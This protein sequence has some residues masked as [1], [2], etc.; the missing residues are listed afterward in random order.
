MSGKPS[1]SRTHQI[2]RL[3]RLQLER[4]PLEQQSRQHRTWL[5]RR[6]MLPPQE[7]AGGLVPPATGVGGWAGWTGASGGVV[8]GTYAASPNYIDVA[9]MIGANAFNIGRV[10][11][12]LNYFGQAWDRESRTPGHVNIS[13]AAAL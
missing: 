1:A 12:I 6:R 7:L 10:W 13:G 8:M 5:G 11:N 3:K 9:E 4:P 2:V